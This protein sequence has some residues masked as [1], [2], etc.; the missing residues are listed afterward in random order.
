M[1]S[2][3]SAMNS[4]NAAMNS[5]N[6]AMNSSNTSITESTS[7]EMFTERVPKMVTLSL[8]PSTPENISPLPTLT[9]LLPYIMPEEIMMPSI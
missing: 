9:S 6:D 2:S 5:S 8:L 7:I 3:N 4:S 1:N